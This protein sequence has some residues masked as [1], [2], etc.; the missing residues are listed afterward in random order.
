MRWLYLLAIGAAFLLAGC[1]GNHQEEDP[2]AAA[3]TAVP[4][5]V[6]SVEIADHPVTLTYPARVRS[7]AQAE[8]R[9]QVSGTL[10]EQHFTEGAHL[11]KG[12]PLFTIDPARYQAAVAVAQAAHDEAA[13]QWQRAEALFKANAISQS[14]HDQARAAYKS[15]QATLQAAKIDL[16]DTRILAPIAGHAGM[17]TLDVGNLISAGTHLLTLTQSDPLYAEFSLSNPGHLKAELTPPSGDWANLSEVAVTLTDEQGQEHPHR[18]S[19]DFMDTAITPGSNSIKLRAR[20]PNPDHTL[21][22]NSFARVALNGFI[23]PDAIRIPQTAVMQ[24]PQGSFVYVIEAGH[25]AIRPVRIYREQGAYFL[26][27]G[28]LQPGDQVIVNN[29]LKI[30]PGAP[31]TAIEGA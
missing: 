30:R 19:I 6:M 31:V 7:G 9:A 21:L 10:L 26:L 24:S 14:E 25:A 29:L 16:G 3:P 1:F 15:T 11:S 23:L 18:G 13:R 22:P 20:I 27:S 12:A 5:G 4:V 28:G 8:V 2:Q 17:R